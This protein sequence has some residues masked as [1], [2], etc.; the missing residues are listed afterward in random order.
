MSSEPAHWRSPEPRASA[1]GEGSVPVAEKLQRKVDELEAANRKL[2]AVNGALEKKLAERTA[3]LKRKD[4]ALMAS[5]A[6][7]QAFAHTAAHD[8][9]APLRAI[10]GFA[11]FLGEELGQS[12]SAPAHSHLQR[13]KRGAAQMDR[14]VQDLLDY[15]KVASAEVRLLPIKLDRIVRQV[16]SQRQT[17]IDEKRGLVEVHVDN[18][19]ILGVEVLLVQVLE[20]LLSNALKFVPAKVQPRVVIR[21]EI[22]RGNVLL[23]VEDNGIG[24]PCE[25]Q[26][27]I[28]EVFER[29]HQQDVY[30]GTG[31]GLAIVRKGIERMGGRIRVES[32]VGKGSRFC[33]ELQPAA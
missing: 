21:A 10:Q 20:N 13:I 8:L 12:A 14:L 22:D 32:E 7:L 1:S 33:I 26:D 16:I 19:E 18:I 29:L 24:I 9:R 11:A 15:S 3:D 4:R 6:E 27:R 17:D 28:F 5:K 31:I 23:C 30:P 2:Q 25:Y